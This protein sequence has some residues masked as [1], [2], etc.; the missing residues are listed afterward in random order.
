M[1]S[2]FKFSTRRRF[3]WL[4]HAAAEA[5]HP[6]PSIP[7]ACR[8]APSTSVAVR[9]GSPMDSGHDSWVF[10]GKRL[11]VQCGPPSDGTMVY[12]PH[13]YYSYRYHKP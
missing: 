9:W 5:G 10:D 7:Q 6:F 4:L 2:I 13:E 3:L 8:C 12:Q 1:K 11:V